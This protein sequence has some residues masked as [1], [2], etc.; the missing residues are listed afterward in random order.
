MGRCEI[1]NQSS[2]ISRDYLFEAQTAIRKVEGLDWIVWRH[3]SKIPNYWRVWNCFKRVLY[4]AHPYR[5]GG[6]GF[7]PTWPG[8]SYHV[9]GN[10]ALKINI[11]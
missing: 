3:C 6:Q 8:H 5:A 9:W 10:I 1:K 7:G 11:F 4:E 2:K